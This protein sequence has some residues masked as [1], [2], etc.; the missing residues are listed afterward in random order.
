MSA[1]CLDFRRDDI[2]VLN[3]GDHQFFFR[4]KGALRE[5]KVIYK[6]FLVY[7]GQRSSGRGCGQY[8]KSAVK[9][10]FGGIGAFLKVQGGKIL[11][12]PGGG[13]S[14]MD[15]CTAY[16]A[17]RGYSAVNIVAEDKSGFFRLIHIRKA[18]IF[19]LAQKLVIFLKLPV[20]HCFRYQGKKQGSA[21]IPAFLYRIHLGGGCG[22]IKAPHIEFPVFLIKY[23]HMRFPGTALVFR[24]N[25]FILGA[26]GTFGGAGGG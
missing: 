12:V 24:H 6:V 5:S 15:A 10:A 18:I 4:G 26:D 22:I 14:Q 21:C 25:L 3:T 23:H 11:E 20:G 2:P 8:P 13:K 9:H 17:G 7:D 19:T 16:R 1:D